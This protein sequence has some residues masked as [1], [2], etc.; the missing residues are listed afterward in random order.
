M[1]LAGDWPL[2]G[3]DGNSSSIAL[4]GVGPISALAVDVDVEF[5]H[6]GGLARIVLVDD[7]GREYLVYESFPAIE[8]LG[9]SWT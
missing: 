7:A 5:D 8:N 9:A 4:V 2:T 6:P 3:S 1:T